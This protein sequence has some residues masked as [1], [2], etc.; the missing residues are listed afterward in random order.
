MSDEE[1][2]EKNL[3]KDD[4]GGDGGKGC[5]DTCRVVPEEFDLISARA[6]EAKRIRICRAEKMRELPLPEN[7]NDDPLCNCDEADYRGSEFSFPAMYSKGLKHNPD[8]GEVLLDSYEALLDGLS[9]S[10]EGNPVK[11]FDDILENELGDCP[12]D[13]E[14]LADNTVRELS[15]QQVPQAR[16]NPDSKNFPL[17]NPL[18]AQAFELQGADSHQLMIFDWENSS[19]GDVK[20]TLF[21]K[22]PKFNSADIIAEMAEVYWMALTRDIPFNRYEEKS[23]DPN[24][25]I[26][27]AISNLNKF[28]YFQRLFPNGVN[29]GN[30][31]RGRLNGDDAGPFLSQ[32]LARPVPYAAF[33]IDPRIRTVKKVNPD[34]SGEAAGGGLDYLICFDGKHPIDE[35]YGSW[36]NVQ[37]GCL[38][39][40]DQF[41]DELSLI[42]TGRD[43]GQYVHVDSLFE[44]YINACQILQVAVSP[45][46]PIPTGLMIEPDDGSGENPV[47][48][49]FFPPGFPNLLGPGNPYRDSTT[50]QGFGTLGIPDVKVLI[51][52]A[53][54]RALKAAW[55]Q[56]WSVHRRLRPEEFGGRVESK[57][58]RGRNYDFDQTA[59]AI[60]EQDVL[61][62]IRE[63]NKV[64]FSCESNLLPMAFP[65]GCPQHPAYPQGHATVAGACVT[66]L[67][68]FFNDIN[69]S[70]NEVTIVAPAGRNTLGK[71]TGNDASEM[72]V[73]GELNKLASNVGLGRDFAGVHWRTDYS[74]GLRLGEAVAVRMLQDIQPTYFEKVSFQFRPFYGD[75]EVSISEGNAEFNR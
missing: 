62:L 68:A 25:L 11:K 65:E 46:A 5:K 17:V 27:K 13:D 45:S 57:I 38:Q 63:H 12:D 20:T 54:K 2:R 34:V 48:G 43:L 28:E 49:G 10:S 33:I 1:N 39:P 60:L 19:G 22:P 51:A 69:L 8:N 56:K 66:I 24:S 35:R 40:G 73:H 55:Y 71:Y 70:E 4:K 21:P 6:D 26:A 59:F 7:S 30:L 50:Q 31:F 53:A 47:G 9:I 14:T 64:N 36:L 18:A 41:D 44:Q 3:K 42:R 61:L 75:G 37:N 32:Y 16:A 67:K 23:R 52:E 58:K 72:T 15:V 74:A 29:A